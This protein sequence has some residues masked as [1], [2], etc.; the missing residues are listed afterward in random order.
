MAKRDNHPAGRC[1]VP[2]AAAAIGG[3]CVGRGVGL[4]ALGALR[5]KCSHTGGHG[6]LSNRF[7]TMSLAQG[8]Q[9]MYVPHTGVVG[10]VPEAVPCYNVALLGCE[11]S[12]RFI[13][14]IT[15]RPRVTAHEPGGGGAVA[16]PTK[17]RA[18]GAASSVLAGGTCACQMSAV[19]PLLHASLPALMPAC[20]C[21][22]NRAAP[23]CATTSSTFGRLACRKARLAAG[24]KFVSYSS[25]LRYFGMK[26]GTAAPQQTSSGGL[27]Q[28]LLG[29][30]GQAGPVCPEGGYIR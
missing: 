21:C 23:S 18:P 2:F 11:T 1:S 3:E 16:P 14:R 26:W 29:S 13:P 10:A 24:G 7:C 8:D 19:W 28:G 25:P 22:C 20:Q 17:Q 4:C 15:G 5:G 9:S 6:Q 12:P 27:R 30:S